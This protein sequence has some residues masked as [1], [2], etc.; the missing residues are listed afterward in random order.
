MNWRPE[1][2]KWEQAFIEAVETHNTAIRGGNY[3][4][5]LFEAGADAMLEALK[6]TGVHI[7]ENQNPLNT[8]VGGILDFFNKCER[9]WLVFIPDEEKN[10]RAKT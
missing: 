1:I 8:T 2:V 6:N 9:G 10:A 7:D 4:R 5:I 3:G